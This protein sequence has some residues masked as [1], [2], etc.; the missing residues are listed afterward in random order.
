MPPVSAQGRTPRSELFQQVPFRRHQVDPVGTF[1]SSFH[2]LQ[3]HKISDQTASKARGPGAALDLAAW[4]STKKRSG[5]SHCAREN[6]WG[7]LLRVISV[8][9]AL[10]LDVG[11]IAAASPTSRA[12]RRRGS[13]PAGPP[14]R[15]R[16]AR[17]APRSDSGS[18][19]KAFVSRMPARS[20][21]SCQCLR[22]WAMDAFASG[23]ADSR[24]F[25]QTASSALSHS[26]ACWRSLARSASVSCAAAP[27][28]VSSPARGEDFSDFASP[29][30]GE[31]RVGVFFAH[32]AR[33]AAQAAL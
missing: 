33:A 20:V 9:L 14:R 4:P 7:V 12:G 29:L 11:A 32:P 22:V 5:P 1:L 28:P 21:S 10:L 2:G 15:P 17:Q 26:R 31:V 24:S 8:F 25:V 30:M 18:E 6:I 23:E 27:P 3:Q 13:S 16:G 19:P